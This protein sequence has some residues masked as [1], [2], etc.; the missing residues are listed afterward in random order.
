MGALQQAILKLLADGGMSPNEIV[1]KLNGS[2]T[3]WDVSQREVL[4]A[5]QG[6]FRMGKVT[7]TKSVW[8]LEN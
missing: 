1:S 8:R 3:G 6:L 2:P 5:L 4:S 7:Q